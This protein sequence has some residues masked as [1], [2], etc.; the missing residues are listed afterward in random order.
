MKDKK[1]YCSILILLIFLTF[2][3]S[4]YSWAL[5]YQEI[6]QAYYL[7]YFYERKGDYEKA[8]KALAPVYN[9]YPKGYTVNLRMGWLYYRWKKYANSIYH[10]KIALNTIPTSL[11]ALLGLSLPLMAQEKWKEVESL[12]YRILKTDFYNYYG[13]LRLCKAL[14]AQKKYKLLE[15]VAR[16]M[17]AIYPTDVNFLNELAIALYYQN[18]KMYAASIFGDVLILDPGNAIAKKFLSIMNAKTK[19]R[20]D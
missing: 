10:Y 4:S 9:T 11:E 20:N 6:K 18:K 19:K 1:T 5:N 3:S 13:N 2:F 16:K 12:M 14:E 8:I 17:L 7:S 15:K